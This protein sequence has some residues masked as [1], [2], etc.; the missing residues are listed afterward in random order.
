MK[1]IMN[2]IMMGL[3]SLSL[4]SVLLA[5]CTSA[6]E[7]YD[8]ENVASSRTV[9]LNAVRIYSSINPGYGKAVYFTGDFYEGNSWQTAVRG[10]YENGQ[11]YADVKASGSFEYKELTG[12]YDEGETVDREFE[13][14]TLIG[15]ANQ[16]S[17]YQ[18]MPQS[19]YYMTG[20]K[21]GFSKAVYF[22]NKNAGL[23]YAVRGIYH[24]R[25]AIGYSPYYDDVWVLDDD[26][27]FLKTK[28][29][30]GDVYAY[31]GNYDEGE[32]LE[33]KFTNLTWAEG[34]NKKYN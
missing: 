31:V 32:V 26:D 33:S 28:S 15:K 12:S 6:F 23:P 5:G 16:M 34:E 13:A 18:G 27:N 30:T 4:A 24:E 29:Y 7:S 9:S 14:L 19:D 20:D 22:Y 2:K 11:W 1:K 10:T 21:A 3:I 8:G 17:G 25:I